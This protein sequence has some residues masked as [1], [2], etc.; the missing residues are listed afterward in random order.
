MA[1]ALAVTP[2]A[3][4]LGGHRS[5]RQE[6][7]LPK[8]PCC[9]RSDKR[10]LPGWPSGV[11]S[12]WARGDHHSLNPQHPCGLTSGFTCFSCW[13]PVLLALKFKQSL[14]PSLPPGQS[15]FHHFLFVC[16]LWWLRFAL[17][18][19]SF[20]LF[21]NSTSKSLAKLGRGWLI[22]V[23]QLSKV[24]PLM[25]DIWRKLVIRLKMRTFQLRCFCYAS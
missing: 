14:F 20:F 19:T 21:P 7:L 10:V 15:P 17:W 16:F 12:L 24:M 2:L 8:F 13:L 5:E 9:S 23:Y 4:R 6:P 1:P 18:D 11:G 22:S 25:V 3:G